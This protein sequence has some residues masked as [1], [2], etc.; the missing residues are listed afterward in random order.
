VRSFE[1][2]LGA[3]LIKNHGN[4]YQ[5]DRPAPWRVNRPF[6][7]S[8]VKVTFSVFGL[9]PYSRTMSRVV[10]RPAALIAHTVE[11]FDGKFRQG[12]ERILFALHLHCEPTFLLLQGAHEEE[13]PGLPVRRFDSDGGLRLAQGQVVAFLAVFDDTFERRIRKQRILVWRPRNAFANIMDQKDVEEAWSVDTFNA[14]HFNVG[15]GAR[16]GDGGDQG[17]RMRATVEVFG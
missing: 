5:V 8:D 2:V 1:L 15:R 6:S 16:A 14:R 4:P 9:A 17:G 12:G 13:Q 11:D 7:T 10:T 3:N